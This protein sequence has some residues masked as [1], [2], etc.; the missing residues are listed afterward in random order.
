[1]RTDRRLA[2]LLVTLALGAITQGI[3]SAAETDVSLLTISGNRTL[4]LKTLTGSDLNTMALGSGREAPFLVNVSD[5]TYDRRGYQVTAMMSNL[6]KFDPVTSTYDCSK[7]IDSN[8]LSINFAASPNSIRGVSAMVSPA[9]AFAGT[10][11]NLADA[12]LLTALGLPLSSSV[13]VAANVTEQIQDLATSTVFSGLENALPV[14]LTSLAG[15]AFAAQAPHPTCDTSASGATSVQLQRGQ[16]N[17]HAD[18]LSWMQNSSNALYNAAAGSNGVLSIA[19]GVSGGL[20]TQAAADTA[21]RTALTTAPLN[22]NPLLIT[23]TVLASVESLLSAPAATVSSVLKQTGSYSSIPQLAVGD[24]AG[25]PTGTYKGK[26]TI[27]LIEDA[28]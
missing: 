26:M 27:T 7:V 17:N 19:E 21:I 20:I 15:A 10:I 11:S 4:T 8:D 16:A 23:S 12:A 2:A 22:V 6:Y 14:K 18:L 13:N 5:I 3:A 25:I 9:L 28:P 24:L 1:M